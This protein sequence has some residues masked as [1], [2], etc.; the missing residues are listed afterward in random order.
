MIL[1]DRDL[2]F[3]QCFQRTS[4]IKPG[5]SDKAV[6]TSPN[7][8]FEQ[9]AALHDARGSSGSREAEELAF[10]GG[11]EASAQPIAHVRMLG[12]IA[13]EEA[14]KSGKKLEDIVTLANGQPK[15]TTLKLS[16]DVRTY[17]GE[18]LPAQVKD[19]YSELT[20]GKPAGDLPH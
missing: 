12:V 5:G 11:H 18:P 2:A 10:A 13:V 6:E 16:E 3:D 14:V 4:A 19:A 8:I 17:V 9:C 7:H 20:S 1:G 15:S